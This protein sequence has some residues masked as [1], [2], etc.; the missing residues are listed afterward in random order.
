MFIPVFIHVICVCVYAC[1]LCVLFSNK[2]TF[3]A[4]WSGDSDTLSDSS[5]AVESIQSALRGHLTRVMAM[6]DLSTHT[7][8]LGS[9]GYM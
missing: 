6:K 9:G 7:P 5:E 8:P 2:T 4:N 1:N 3:E